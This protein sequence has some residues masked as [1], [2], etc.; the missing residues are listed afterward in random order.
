[1]KHNQLPQ[2]KSLKSAARELRREQTPQEKRLW[3]EYLSS[4][5]VRFNRQKVIG[6]YIVDFYCRKVNLVIELDGGQHYEK[7]ALEYDEKRT[8]YLTDL[9]IRVLRF[10]NTDIQKHLDEVCRVI[11]AVVKERQSSV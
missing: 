6:N 11:D 5:P 2:N 1:M 8:Q 7:E 9:G 3:Y 10:T 4:Y